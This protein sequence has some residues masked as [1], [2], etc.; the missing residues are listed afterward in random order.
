[1]GSSRDLSAARAAKRLRTAAVRGAGM[2]T[3]RKTRPPA[4]LLGDVHDVV[5]TDPPADAGARRAP[6]YEQRGHHP[7][8]KREVRQRNDFS[9]LAL[10]WAWAYLGVGV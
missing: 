6:G 2:K 1:G 8:A 7:E 9:L 5:P 4:P 10:A 3:V